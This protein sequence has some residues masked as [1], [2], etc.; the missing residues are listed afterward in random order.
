[1][2][3]FWLSTSLPLSG[4]CI[5]R[6][7]LSGSG[8]I[9]LDDSYGDIPLTRNE[10]SRDGQFAAAPV[11]RNQPCIC[12]WPA[13]H[14]STRAPLT[15]SRRPGAIAGGAGHMLPPSGGRRT[16]TGP[17]SL[18]VL[19]R[20]ATGDRVGDAGIVRIGA[21]YARV[22]GTITRWPDSSPGS[23]PPVADAFHGGNRPSAMREASALPPP[24]CD[25][26][27][28]QVPGRRDDL[29]GRTRVSSVVVATVA[30][31]VSSTRLSSANERAGH[32]FD[33]A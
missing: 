33:A 7:L 20:R 30:S 5:A 24:R 29:L 8:L 10:G 17:T 14:A 1:M 6:R 16:I 13:L 27:G 23:R 18:F 26:H 2:S 21:R 22:S 12:N 11:R 19:A 3:I 9:P 31:S 28:A 15:A 32:D 25:V 4:S